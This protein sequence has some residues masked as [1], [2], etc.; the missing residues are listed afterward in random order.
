MKNIQLKNKKNL[1]FLIIEAL[2][3]IMI[4]GFALGTL[5]EISALS[6]KISTS[7]RQSDQANFLLKETMESARNFRDGTTWSINGLGSLN[8][9]SS[10]PYYFSLD[11]T[12]TPNQWNINS[13]TQTLGMFTRNVVFDKV[14]RDP[15]TGNIET[16][17]NAS[18][19]DPNTKKVT[20][21]VAG[22]NKTLYLTTY[23]T[24][25]KP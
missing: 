3:A 13:G 1:G 17:Y 23:V 6:V 14:S 18:H 16:T 12:V 2:L 8:T 21:T 25:W 11:T 19:D 20:L 24:N 10:N 15:A 4:I 7:I 22:P 9:G 5:L